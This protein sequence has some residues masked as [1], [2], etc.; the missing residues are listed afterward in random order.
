M[1]KVLLAQPIH[2]AA[3]DLL[4]Q[5]TQVVLIKEGN[6]DEFKE[7]LKDTYA[8]I[9]GTSVKFTSDLMDIA[10]EL[11]VISRTG[12]GVDNV[13]VKAATQRGI[14]VLNTPEANSLS[15]AEHTVM[16]I[17]ALA[18]HAIFLDNQLRNNNY[19]VRRLYLPVDLQGKILGLVGC[20]RIG[21]MVAQKCIK[22]FDMNVIAYDPVLKVAPE[23]ITLAESIDEVFQTADFISLHIPL[24]ESTRNL[25]NE[26]LLSLMKPS[27][28]LI[29]TAR[30]GIVDEKALIAK[31]KEKK[32]AGAALDVFLKEPPDPAD[33]LLTL[34][35]IILTPHTAALTQECTARVAMEA[36]KGVIDFIQGKTPRFVYNKEVLS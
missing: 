22:A 6:M 28:F 26:R 9:L 34:P 13:D 30:G 31:L 23:E 5:Y 29:N 16:M 8:V 15:V 19:G 24:V 14:Y 4:K 25:V 33:E 20:G 18:K 36:V 21:T 32:I 12:V 3:M 7:H 10:P 11:K 2:S 27:A 35:N 1:K 17:C